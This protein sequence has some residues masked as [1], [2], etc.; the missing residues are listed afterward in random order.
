MVRLE[1]SLGEG[2]WKLIFHVGGKNQTFVASVK[3]GMLS[4][5]RL[6]MIFK[7]KREKKNDFFF[8]VMNNPKSK[9]K[10]LILIQFIFF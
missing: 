3:K 7:F 6:T 1:I 4:T 10:S 2:K 5:I 9:R 8:F